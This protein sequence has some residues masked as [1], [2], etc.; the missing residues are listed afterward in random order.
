MY[1]TIIE[2]KS[3]D[4]LKILKTE[5]ENLKKER[6]EISVSDKVYIEAKD[7]VALKTCLST[8]IK[9][10]EIYEKMESVK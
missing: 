2:I 1:N 5:L 8:V 6:F 10:L 3:R 7:A 9:I 4:K